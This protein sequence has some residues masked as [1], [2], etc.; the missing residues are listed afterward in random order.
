MQAKVP[1]A[2]YLS[3]EDE[4]TLSITYGNPGTESFGR[5]MFI[6]RKMVE[7]CSSFNFQTA[8]AIS[9]YYIER[10][11]QL[12]ALTTDPAFIQTSQGISSYVDR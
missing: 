9:H 8:L 10:R 12:A 1:D 5:Q 4:E 11:H 3:G 2:I 7:K 6:A